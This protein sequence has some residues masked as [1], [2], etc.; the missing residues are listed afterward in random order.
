M[1]QI[2]FNEKTDYTAPTF[3]EKLKNAVSGDVDSVNFIFGHTP[4]LDTLQLIDKLL[5]KYK[6]PPQVML[7]F[8]GENA[9]GIADFS[10]LHSVT[11]LNIQNRYVSSLE[12]VQLFPNLNHVSITYVLEKELDFT[13]LVQCKSLKC[14]DVERR[15]T[16][17]QHQAISKTPKLEKLKAHGLNISQLD[18]MPYLSFLEVH[19]LLNPME[20][21]K[22]LP[23]LK[24]LFILS[25][26]SLKDLGFLSD[27]A[28]LEK[29]RIIKMGGIREFPSFKENNSLTDVYLRD[30][31]NLCE[32]D[33][34]K[35]LPQ[36]KK[37]RLEGNINLAQEDL[38]W[39]SKK[40][41]P[42]L[43]KLEFN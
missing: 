28:K 3:A 5:Q 31:G 27:M 26:N 40:E 38:A 17:K 37:L 30:M 12:G 35:T 9:L 7:T 11:Y 1:N 8:A 32:F 14:L 24:D 20:F 39:F 21:A 22:K 10:A 2:I 36:L 41:F 43:E 16:K 6:A 29:L 33:N 13:P 42:C 23:C 25:S 4:L 18:I 19:G 34:L 15:L